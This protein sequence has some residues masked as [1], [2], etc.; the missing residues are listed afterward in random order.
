MPPA[1]DH[2]F[3]AG[4]WSS[5]FDSS[6]IEIDPR[7]RAG[8]RKIEPGVGKRA[9]FGR[10]ESVARTNPE[11]E[12]GSAEATRPPVLRRESGEGRRR[13]R[14]AGAAAAKRNSRNARAGPEIDQGVG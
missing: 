14:V 3:V 10:L 2:R 12:I 8:G 1:N 7:H 9:R 5:R 4:T 13:H 6:R 11:I